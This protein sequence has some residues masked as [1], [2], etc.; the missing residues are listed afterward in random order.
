M[1]LGA[2]LRGRNS[3]VALPLLGQADACFD[4]R[5]ALREIN[6][7]DSTDRPKALSPTKNKLPVGL[8]KPNEGGLGC[9]FCKFPTRGRGKEGGG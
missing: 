2:A 7:Y 6:W 5:R 1:D 9:V 8:Q 3:L 4:L